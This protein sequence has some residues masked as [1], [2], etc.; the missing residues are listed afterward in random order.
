MGGAPLHR[1]EGPVEGQDKIF[2][3]P[4]YHSAADGKV[5]CKANCVADL[6]PF[7]SSG[8][9]EMTR[10]NVL[11]ESEGEMMSEAEK[12]SNDGG[13]EYEPTIDDPNKCA[14]AWSR[15]AAHPTQPHQREA[16]SESAATGVGGDS[17]RLVKESAAS[18]AECITCTPPMRVCLVSRMQHS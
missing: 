7:A 1:P 14:A 3:R 2:T 18:N 12:I 4:P 13:L 15:G 6:V 8:R 9:F 16:I 10:S 11:S 17:R 5:N